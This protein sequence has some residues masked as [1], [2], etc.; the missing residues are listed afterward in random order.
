MIVFKCFLKYNINKSSKRVKI[1]ELGEMN[2]LRA[3]RD[4]VPSDGKMG[5]CGAMRKP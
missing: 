1:F 5:G 2:V 3:D 4:A